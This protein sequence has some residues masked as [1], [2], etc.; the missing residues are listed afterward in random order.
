MTSYQWARQTVYVYQGQGHLDPDTILPAGYS[1][2]DITPQKH[3]YTHACMAWEITA[4]RLQL[5][6]VEME[7]FLMVCM[8]S[9]AYTGTSLRFHSPLI[10]SLSVRPSAFLLVSL[11]MH[12]CLSVIPSLSP[13]LP[14][15]SS[16]PPSFPRSLPPTLPPPFLPTYTSYPLSVSVCVCL[17]PSLSLSLSLSL[18]VQ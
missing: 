6:R 4:Y 13:S 8:D 18:C 17:S 9:I 5:M 14:F 10:H 11:S 3:Q 7:I 12:P 16:H 1:C 2:G 15:S